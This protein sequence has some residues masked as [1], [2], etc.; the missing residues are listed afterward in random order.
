M[1]SF[2]MWMGRSG[3]GP[4]EL[5]A[6]LARWTQQGSAGTGKISGASACSAN[7]PCLFF[8]GNNSFISIGFGGNQLMSGRL[9][10]IMIPFH[11]VQLTA[12]EGQAEAMSCRRQNKD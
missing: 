2:E 10:E 8:Y 4:I 12:A 11:R 1:L 7:R 9:V 5:E 3:W 6:G